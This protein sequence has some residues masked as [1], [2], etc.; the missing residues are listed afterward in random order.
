MKFI[1]SQISKTLQK[2]QHQIPL[3]KFHLLDYHKSSRSYMVLNTHDSEIKS[4]FSH[5]DELRFT[6]ALSLL[7]F[8][9]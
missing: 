6:K 2:E 5:I 1:F 9:Y 4:P 3:T 8:I 7:S